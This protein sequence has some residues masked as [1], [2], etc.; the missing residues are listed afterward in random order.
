MSKK[1]KQEQQKVWAMKTMEVYYEHLRCLD[2]REKYEQEFGL[3]TEADL[4]KVLVISNYWYSGCR[5]YP[6]GSQ[7]DYLESVLNKLEGI[8]TED[9]PIE[10]LV[11]KVDSSEYGKWIWLAESDS[12]KEKICLEAVQ[13]HKYSDGDFDYRLG[14]NYIIIISEEFSGTF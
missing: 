9:K 7:A 12:A 3:F 8:L 2:I 10:S 14:P 5:N 1:T 6:K 11:R 13:Q 4:R